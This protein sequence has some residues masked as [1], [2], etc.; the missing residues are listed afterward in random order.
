L[1]QFLWVA[2]LYIDVTNAS[3]VDTD[4]KLR[5]VARFISTTAGATE[6]FAEEADHRP[7]H[8]AI[9]IPNHSVD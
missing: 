3:F 4:L 8:R 9:E 1:D 6:V 5:T 2:L 7:P